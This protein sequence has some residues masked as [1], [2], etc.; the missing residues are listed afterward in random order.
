MQAGRDHPDRLR[1][2]LLVGLSARE[3]T[4][5][6]VDFSDGELPGAC[7]DGADLRAADFTGCDLR[8]ASFRN[9]N[10]GHAQLSK[11]DISSLPLRDG[12]VR[13][14]AS[15]VRRSAAASVFLSNSAIVS[16]PTPPGTGEIAPATSATDGCTSPI[17]VDPFLSN[18]A[19]RG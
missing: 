5:I 15:S 13:A 8:G 4:A 14:T 2:R 11:A 10:L 19:M 16:G 18:N 7:F 9:A 17:T 6:G 1:G 3:V 12:T